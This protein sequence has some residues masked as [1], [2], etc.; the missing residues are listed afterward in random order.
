VVAGLAVAAPL[1]WWTVYTGILAD[2][3]MALLFA[4]EYVVR[5]MRRQRFA[6][7]QANELR[8]SRPTP[9]GDTAPPLFPLR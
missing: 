4:T 7:E 9:N 8:R 3:L 6:N 1:A 2:V 5:T